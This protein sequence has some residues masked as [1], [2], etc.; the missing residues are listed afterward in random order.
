M[1][2]QK[3]APVAVVTGAGTGIGAAT[4]HRFA[5]DGYTVVLVGRTD[6]HRRRLLRLASCAA[7]PAGGARLHRQRRIRGRTAR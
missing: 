6:Q 4:A 5:A 1:S 2:Q 7:P 3:S